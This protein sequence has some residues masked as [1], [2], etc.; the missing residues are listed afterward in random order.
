MAQFQ[1]NSNM[2]LLLKLF[3]IWVDSFSN[4][5]PSWKYGARRIN[6]GPSQMVKIVKP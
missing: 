5:S 2:S 6:V 3:H 1:I 4:D